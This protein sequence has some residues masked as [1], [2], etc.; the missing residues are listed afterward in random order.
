MVWVDYTVIGVILLSALVGLA[1]GLM[2]EVLSFVIWLGALLIAWTFFRELSSELTR[3]L[4]S[5]MIRLG[6]AFLILVFAVL[7]VG[8]IFGHLLSALVRK[9][10]L[11][12][13]DRALGMVF[14]VA[15]GTI[16][17]AMLAFLAALTPFPQEDWWQESSLI[18]RFQVLAKRVIDQIPPVVVDKLKSF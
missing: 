12:G 11:T 18:G 6:A 17:V 4:P 3:W 8:A 9:T 15:R 1:R 13:T 2:R 10:G 16:L 5:P 7:I 14:G